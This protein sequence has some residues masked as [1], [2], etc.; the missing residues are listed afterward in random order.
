MSQSAQINE[1]HRDGWAIPGYTSSATETPYRTMCADGRERWITVPNGSVP[2]VPHPKV[3]YL[4]VARADDV[5][6]VDGERRAQAV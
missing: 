2:L 5:L 3:S 1:M 6:R 4:H